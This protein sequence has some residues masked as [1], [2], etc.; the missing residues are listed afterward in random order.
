MQG[1]GLSHRR[2]NSTSQIFEFSLC[3]CCSSIMST[4]DDG[5]QNHLQPEMSSITT[6]RTSSANRT[7]IQIRSSFLQLRDLKSIL[8][9]VY[10]ERGGHG[11]KQRT[12]A[13]PGQG[14]THRP[15]S[16]DS[17]PA[18]G[19]TCAGREPL[20]APPPSCGPDSSVQVELIRAEQQEV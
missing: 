5:S 15:P 9:E 14:P 3:R 12:R 6:C 1:G 7:Q 2:N 4:G 10:R 16:R 17:E 8:H 11:S 19:N 20:N 18:G 13:N